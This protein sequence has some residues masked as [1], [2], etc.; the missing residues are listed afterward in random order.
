MLGSAL[1]LTTVL[2]AWGMLGLDERSVGTA[3][4]VRQPFA[5]AVEQR[6]GIIRELRE[7]KVLLQ[8]QNALLRAAT[9]PK[10]RKDRQE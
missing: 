8:E 2:V 4:T 1:L 3:Q 5:S 9:Q 7:I 10:P 6:N